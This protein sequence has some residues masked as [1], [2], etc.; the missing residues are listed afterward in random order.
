MCLAQWH[1][2]VMPVRLDHAA[3][4]SRV[5]HWPTALLIRP[6]MT[7]QMLTVVDWG[8]KNQTQPNQTLILTVYGGARIVVV[9]CSADSY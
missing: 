8:E 4:R 2:A 9:C 6:D 3:P 1:N 5:K 7:E